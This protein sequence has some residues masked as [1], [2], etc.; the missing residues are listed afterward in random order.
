MF[1]VESSTQTAWRCLQENNGTRTRDPKQNVDLVETGFTSRKDFIVVRFSVTRN[2]LPDS[3]LYRF[4][5]TLLKVNR[6]RQSVC[7]VFAS[8]FSSCGIANVM[9]LELKL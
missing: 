7:N 1:L 5:G 2:G 9:V 4:Q 6:I 8:M 3:S